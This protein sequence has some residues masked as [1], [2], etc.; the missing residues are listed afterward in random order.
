MTTWSPKSRNGRI[1]GLVLALQQAAA[2]VATSA[3][4]RPWAS[5]TCQR[6][7][8]PAGVGHFPCAMRSLPARLERRQTE[9]ILRLPRAVNPLGESHGIPSP[10]RH[11]LPAPKR[12]PTGRPNERE[13]DRTG[14]LTYSDVR[15]F[16]NVEKICDRTLGRSRGTPRS[17]LVI[18]GPIRARCAPCAQLAPACCL[19]DD[20]AGLKPHIRRVDMWRGTSGSVRQPHN[21]PTG[22]ANSQRAARFPRVS[23]KLGHW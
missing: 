23:P 21:A 20:M 9:R 18:S 19:Q 6:C 12:P 1:G 11:G 2:S 7:S 3:R 16:R 17:G 15:A 13:A 10:S 4:T 14:L 22:G 5:M 8:D